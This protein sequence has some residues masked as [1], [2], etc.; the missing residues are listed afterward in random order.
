MNLPKVSIIIPT[1]N[2]ERFILDAVTSALSQTY[3]NL[4]V[5]VGDDCSTDNSSKLIQSINDSRLTY[6]RNKT[7]LGR[8]QNYRNLLYQYATGD[9]ILNLDGDDYLIYN[10]FISDAIRLFDND[11]VAVA[12]NIFKE[13]ENKNKRVGYSFPNVD[14]L[15]GIDLLMKLP[16]KKFFF[17]HLSTIYCK[18]IATE[19]NFYS[20]NSL[21]SDWESLY[22]L[23]IHGKV[24]FLNKNVAVWRIH[25]NNQSKIPNI[26]SF[27][28]NL[29]IWNNIFDYATVYNFPKNLSHELACKCQFYFINMYIF[30]NIVQ[31]DQLKSRQVL[32]DYL[33]EK[34]KNKY[35]FPITRIILQFPILGLQFIALYFI[36]YFLYWVRS[37]AN[38]FQL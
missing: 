33:I 35:N 21:S 25:S 13:Y 22:R 5:I 38:V 14:Y 37:I 15:T 29:Q 26:D 31:N 28:D 36:S 1:Y 19:I 7:N 34:V 11:V 20:F 12:A 16:D 3:S 18:K 9:Y 8:V 27:V 23:A 4:E 6:V 30:E 10:N 32:P 2:Q 24:K 17:K